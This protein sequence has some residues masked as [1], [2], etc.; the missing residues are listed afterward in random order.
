MSRE[1]LGVLE[2]EGSLSVGS[3]RASGWVVGA[4]GFHWILKLHELFMF[5]ILLSAYH[6]AVLFKTKYVN[7]L[8]KVRQLWVGPREE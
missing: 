1:E 4:Q 5:Y 2:P 3:I 7:R 6:F 8:E